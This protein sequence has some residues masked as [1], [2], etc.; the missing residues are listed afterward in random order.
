MTIADKLYSTKPDKELLKI[1]K[2]LELNT[3]ITSIDADFGFPAGY[4]VIAGNPG[5]GKSWFALWLSRVF[6]LNNAKKSV[7]F[8]LEMPEPIVRQRILQQWSDLTKAQFE[9]EKEELRAVEHLHQDAI[10][11]DTFYADDG[12]Y[13]TTTEFEKLFKEYYSLGYRCFHFDH[14]HE[15]A[16]AN[17]NQTNQK[18]T[19]D[20]AK[21]FQQIVKDYPDV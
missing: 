6:W 15:L 10:V 20:W 14:L 18:V 7:Y 3:G 1:E 21:A 13:Q 19:E 4:Y 5:A 2:K 9:S 12:K 11:V 16:G 8:S 17:V